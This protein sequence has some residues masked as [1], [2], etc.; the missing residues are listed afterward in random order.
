M[1]SPPTPLLDQFVSLVDDD[2]PKRGALDFRIG[3]DLQL[4]FH[5]LI[6]KFQ[7]PSLTRSL[8]KK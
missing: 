6:R 1:N 4:V 2:A 5:D 3:K 8:Y 7:L